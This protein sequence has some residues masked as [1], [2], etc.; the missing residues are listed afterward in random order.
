MKPMPWSHS[1]LS[2]FVN[3]PKAF[4]AKRV[5]KSVKEEQS[6]QIIW[7]NKV[8]K[9]FEDRVHHGR[10]TPLPDY[11]A[12]H[13]P[14]MQELESLAGTTYVERKIALDTRRQPCGFFDKNVWMRGVVD[15]TNVH[16]D[17]ALLVDYKTG[18][19]HSK[20]GQLKLFALHTFAEFPQVD[21]V[22][23]KFYWTKTLS[24]SEDT[25]TRD[26][27]PALWNEFASDLKQYVE[28]FKT[29][30]WQPRPSGLCNGWC[31]VTNCEHWRP[32]RR[33]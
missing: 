4:H 13:E 14:F 23:V 28:A 10:Q 15:V 19:P 20:F 24:E 5:E 27:I 9:A 7:G 3:C 11:L 1:A 33:R 18:K 17:G 16:Q 26:Q 29:N 25:Y 21:F 31:P 2:D 32:K 30:T 6:D 8:H 12:E 22:T